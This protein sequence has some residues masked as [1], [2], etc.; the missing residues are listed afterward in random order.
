MSF[1][2]GLEKHPWTP[3]HTTIDTFSNPR[4]PLPAL[5]ISEDDMHQIFRENKRRKTPGPDCVS[6]TCLKT[7]A[8]QLA[9]IFTKTFYRL[10]ELCEV[11][12]CFKCSTIIHVPKKPKI[13]DLNGYRPVALTSVVMKSFERLVLAYLKAST[14]PLL[15]PCSLP[16]EQTGQHGTALHPAASGQTRD[17]C[18]DPVCRLK[19]RF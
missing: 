11:P 4:S 7:C 10:L 2:V 15:C 12:S 16:T 6:P 13:T 14:G 8:D 1:T 17:L 18:E 19:L 5:K 9:P 3:L